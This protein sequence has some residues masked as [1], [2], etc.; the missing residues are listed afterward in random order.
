MRETFSCSTA[1][2]WEICVVGFVFINSTVKICLVKVQCCNYNTNYNNFLANVLHK[3]EQKSIFLL[4]KRLPWD[5]KKTN[6]NVHFR[7][8]YLHEAGNPS[9]T[10]GFLYQRACGC[11]YIG[12]NKL[13]NKQSSFR[14]LETLW[15]PIVMNLIFS[16][17]FAYNITTVWFVV[18]LCA[19]GH[20]AHIPHCV[21]LRSTS[22]THPRPN[23][24]PPPNIHPPPPPPTHPRPHSASSI[25][26]RNQRCYDPTSLEHCLMT[27]TWTLCHVIKFVR[28]KLL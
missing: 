14:W 19:V 7:T 16:T 27:V 9:V 22:S 13:L 18:S 24:Q 12:L 8:I 11:F 1:Q 21:E 17:D 25:I 2:R 20:C 6:T 23:P 4:L 28:A 10:G 5:K 3:H 15:R 26:Q